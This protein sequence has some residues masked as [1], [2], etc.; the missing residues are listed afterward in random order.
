[1]RTSCRLALLLV[2]AAA[3][4]G[5]SSVEPWVKPYERQYF[6]DVV[7][8]GERDPVAGSYLNHVFEAR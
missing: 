6:A 3:S 4:S 7:M 5:C 2:L 8:S 1:M